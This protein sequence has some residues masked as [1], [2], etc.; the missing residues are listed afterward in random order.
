M[1]RVS[2][3]FWANLKQEI[4]KECFSFINVH[5]HNLN[6]HLNLPSTKFHPFTYL[7]VYATIIYDQI[8]QSSNHGI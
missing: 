8:L 2:S 7:H 4:A 1:Q 3:G 6:L 5:L